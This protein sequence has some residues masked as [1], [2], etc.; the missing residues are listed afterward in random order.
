[1]SKK[2]R[3]ALI[4]GSGSAFP[5]NIKQDEFSSCSIDGAN[6]PSDLRAYQRCSLYHQVLNLCGIVPDPEE[7]AG[8]DKK[9]LKKL[10]R[11]A[12]RDPLVVMANKAISGNSKAFVAMTS[13][14]VAVMRGFKLKI[15]LGEDENGDYLPLLAPKKPGQERQ[16]DSYRQNLIKS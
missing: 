1:M 13:L 12:S 11:L 7:L 9:E 16:P 10:I 5:R 4:L 8:L 15:I 6:L 2:E 14:V 3:T